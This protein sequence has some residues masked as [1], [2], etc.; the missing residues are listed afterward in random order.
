[1]S[2]STVTAAE[3]FARYEEI[4]PRL[5]MGCFPN[6]S[7]AISNLREL[8]DE[9]DVFLLDAF[10]VLNI[11]D[12]AIAGAVERIG[13]LRKA[14]KKIFVLTNSAT[15]NSRHAL[16]KY[17]AFG[18]DFSIE[19]VISS[20]DA[21]LVALKNFPA[22]CHWGVAA[23]PYSGLD[24]IPI[25]ARLLGDDPADYEKVD[26][27][28]FLSA[29]EWTGPQQQLLTQSL[30]RHPRPLIVGNPDLVAPREYGLSREPGF[31]A[32]DIADK[33]GI[34]PDFYGKPFADVFEQALCAAGL[35]DIPK[36]RIA[37]VGDTLHTDI[38]GGAAA[39]LKTVL[40]TDHGILKGQ[41]VSDMIRISGIL[42]DFIAKTT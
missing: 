15:F 16:E 1:M 42:P 40:V 32:H 13:D 8:M 9:I 31:F 5:P 35:G 3:A 41:N 26:A 22:D 27:F 30:A 23:T 6:S 7:R 10:G 36:S 18:F 20:R 39:G 14:G 24:E 4:R 37:M 29:A 38:L 17:H 19:E 33:T 34:T 11:G 25:Q 12:Q 2:L 21:A 28:L